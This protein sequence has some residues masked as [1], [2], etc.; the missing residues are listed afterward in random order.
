[1]TFVWFPLNKFTHHSTA[2]I[3]DLLQLAGVSVADPYGQPTYRVDTDR[4]KVMK[5]I[6]RIVVSQSAGIV[7]RP[8]M[9]LF[10]TDLRALLSS[11]E[12]AFRHHPTRAA[13]WQYHPAGK[14]LPARWSCN[15]WIGLGH[16]RDEIEATMARELDRA[17]H[18][19][20]DDAEEHRVILAM[21]N[22]AG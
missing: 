19:Q 8:C 17:K 2:D 16:P 13:G 7:A 10:D 18:V 6:G 12:D 3:A 14:D 1:M 11:A 9:D 20:A 5:R 15:I 4:G 21:Q 22:T